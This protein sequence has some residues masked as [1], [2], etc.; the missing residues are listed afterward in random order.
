VLAA[1]ALAYVAALLRWLREPAGPGLLTVCLV[2]EDEG[3]ATEVCV[4]EAMRALEAV[5]PCLRAVVVAARPTRGAIWASQ[6]RRQTGVEV[7]ATVDGWLDLPDPVL[8]AGL[9]PGFRGAAL[10]ARARRLLSTTGGG[11]PKRE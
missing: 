9:F 11:A 10:A 3:V 7:A 2:D 4:A 1:L 6:L 8:R 5:G